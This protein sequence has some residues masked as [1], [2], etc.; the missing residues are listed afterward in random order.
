MVVD[1][2]EESGRMREDGRAEVDG[3]R[4]ERA[5]L[6]AA[7]EDRSWGEETPGAMPELKLFHL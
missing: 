5:I 4:A 6:N 7:V 2:E 3:R 1:V